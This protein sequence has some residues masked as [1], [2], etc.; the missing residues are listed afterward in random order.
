MISASDRENAIVL[1]KEATDAGAREKMACHELSISQRTLQ[2][3]RNKA[4][5]LED[6]RPHA[7]RPVP[8]NKLTEEEQQSIITICNQTEF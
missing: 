3:W 1:I 6:Q 4:T 8:R 5:P 2:R 7:S